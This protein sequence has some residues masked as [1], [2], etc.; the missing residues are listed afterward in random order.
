MPRDDGLGGNIVILLL[1]VAVA[2]LFYIHGK[3]F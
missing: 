1:I 3:P 2:V